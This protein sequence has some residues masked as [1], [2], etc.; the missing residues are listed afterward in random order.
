MNQTTKKILSAA[1]TATMAMSMAS[2]SAFA[3]SSA[4]TTNSD[5]SSDLNGHWAKDTIEQWEVSG[6]I[7]GYEDN[8]FRPDSPI[9]R[10]E[11]IK[12]L[13]QIMS[14]KETAFIDFT[15]V[16]IN[17]WYYDDVAIAVASGYASGF[18]DGSF[19]PNDYVTRAQAA[20]FLSKASN[21]AEGS[22]TVLADAASIPS[23]A[24]SAVSG[25]MDAGYM[26]GYPDGTFHPNANLT[27]AEAVTILDRV[28]NG[29]K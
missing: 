27:R 13:N 20:T 16:D 3:A 9:T 1:L 23:W 15:D 29:N 5:V 8:T 4:V 11:F 22:V 10:A 14:Q 24:Q 21:I 19:H 17:D 18:E 25:V 2:F 7:R 26:S 28:L 12:L 6:L